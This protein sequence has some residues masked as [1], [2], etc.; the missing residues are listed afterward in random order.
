MIPVDIY[1]SVEPFRLQSNKLADGMQVIDAKSVLRTN[2]RLSH[3]GVSHQMQHRRF[4]LGCFLINLCIHQ[5]TSISIDYY[6]KIFL[7]K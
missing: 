1:K 3:C 4:S 7:P 6:M 5:G 2:D